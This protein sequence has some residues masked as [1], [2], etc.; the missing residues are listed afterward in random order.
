MGFMGLMGLIGLMGP[1]GLGVAHR[2]V[3]GHAFYLQL[4]RCWGVGAWE[5]YLGLDLDLASLLCATNQYRR[6]APFHST[7]VGIDGGVANDLA[8]A[9]DGKADI[10]LGQA[11][12]MS[13]VVGHLA[14]D[15]DEVGAVSHEWLA[16]VVN[17]E[18]QLRATA[19]WHPP[20]IPSATIFTFC[21]LRWV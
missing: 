15:D 1:M 14:D 12:H 2:Q 19:R 16:H 5:L 6:R 7:W 17:A 9:L 11:T 13:Q 3:V 10:F 21:Q 20:M 8:F 4:G 18:A